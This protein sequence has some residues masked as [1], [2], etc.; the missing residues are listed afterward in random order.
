MVARDLS[1]CTSCKHVIKRIAGAEGYADW[2][3]FKLSD[4]VYEERNSQYDI[5]SWTE[6]EKTAGTGTDF[7]VACIS[8][9]LIY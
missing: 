5:D 9:F 7:G 3:I 6:D 2:M 8:T 1:G 4:A